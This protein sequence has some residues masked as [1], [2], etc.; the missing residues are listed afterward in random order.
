[1]KTEFPDRFAELGARTETSVQR[2]GNAIYVQYENSRLRLMQQDNG[3]LTIPRDALV[4]DTDQ[5]GDT[6]S[7]GDGPQ[8]SPPPACNPCG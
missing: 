7:D 4:L 1:M 3:T 2:R 8:I 5:P 6:G